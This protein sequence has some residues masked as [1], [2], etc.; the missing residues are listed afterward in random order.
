MGIKKV[1]TSIS[2]TLGLLFTSTALA[3]WKNLICKLMQ[4]TIGDI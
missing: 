1:K 3:H 2:D 4:Y